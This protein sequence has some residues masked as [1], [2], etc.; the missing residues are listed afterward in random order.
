MTEVISQLG[1]LFSCCARC[2]YYLMLVAS[3]K[4]GIIRQAI[5]NTYTS[6]VPQDAYSSLKAAG[7]GYCKCLT[8]PSTIEKQ[9]NMTVMLVPY[10]FAIWA[11]TNETQEVFAEIDDEELNDYTTK[12]VWLQ[13]LSNSII[14]VWNMIPAVAQNLMINMWFTQSRSRNTIAHPTPTT[15]HF[16]WCNQTHTSH[17]KRSVWPPPSFLWLSAE[18]VKCCSVMGINFSPLD[19]SKMRCLAAGDYSIIYIVFFCML[20]LCGNCI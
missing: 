19:G 15:Q 10:L 3:D 12:I 16:I 6:I 17:L 9:K 1:S 5:N 20:I 14:L 2:I 8:H 13:N 11:L 18:K 7:Y 4:N